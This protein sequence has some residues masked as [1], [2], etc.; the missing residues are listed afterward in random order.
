[1]RMQYDINEVMKKWKNSDELGRLSIEELDE[2]LQENMAILL[3]NQDTVDYTGDDV[4]N[5]QQYSMS[6]TNIGQINQDAAYKPISLALVRRTFPALFAQNTVGVQAMSTPVGLAFALRVIYADKS[7]TGQV[8]PEA[9]WDS[10][11][12]YSGF[13]GNTSGT[14]ASYNTSGSGT[15]VATSAG[16]AWAIGTDYPQL[17]LTLEQTAIIARTRKLAASFSLEAA[18]DIRAM[19]NIDIEREIVGVL[20]YEMIAELDRELIA[21]L[22]T[23]AVTGTG[24]AAATELNFSA[25]SG[26]GYIDGRWSQEQLASMITAIIFQSETIARKTRRGAGNFVVVSPA[27]A[28]ALQSVRPAFS[29]N[30]ASVTANVAGIARIGTLNGTMAVYR[31]QYATD[32]YALVGYKG[33]TQN[34]AGVIYSPYVT[35]VMNRTVAQEDFSPRI[36]VMSRYAITDSLLGS[37]RYYRFMTFSNVNKVIAGHSSY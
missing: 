23:T 12:T 34:D 33:P 20:Q 18:Q 22:K 6:T 10:V 2:Q 35:G 25:A 8:G 7:I 1:M 26:T 17:K 16:E 28:T 19:H 3:E 32:D 9:A 4:L 27:I 36:G 13:T 11:P 5:E 15:G 29:G 24:G 30:S 14:S 31:D 37:G 21:K